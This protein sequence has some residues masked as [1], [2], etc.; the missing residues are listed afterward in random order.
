[1]EVD[2]S[3]TGVE[4]LFGPVGVR[5]MGLS[6]R[7]ED[8]EEVAFPIE[9]WGVGL[10]HKREMYGTVRRGKSNSNQYEKNGR[11]RPNSPKIHR[12]PLA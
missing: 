3:E 6:R 4:T 8:G 12:H 1:M 2:G 9:G 5:L 11:K 10:V 7:V